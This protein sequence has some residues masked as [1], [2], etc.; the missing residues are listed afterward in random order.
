MRAPRRFVM[1]LRAAAYQE[2][3]PANGEESL[4]FVDVV[5]PTLPQDDM[6]VFAERQLQ[7]PLG[8]RGDPPG[9][10]QLSGKPARR[11]TYVKKLF[12]GTCASDCRA[13]GS[14]QPPGALPFASSRPSKARTGPRH[15]PC[16]SCANNAGHIVN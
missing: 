14:A 9:C 6:L 13:R 12:R 4:E 2:I 8:E 7:K 16:R 11:R 1:Q 5:P 15:T 10:E 3:P